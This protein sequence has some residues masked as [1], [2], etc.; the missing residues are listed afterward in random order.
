MINH[1]VSS[2]Q[3]QPPCSQTVWNVL[4]NWAVIKTKVQGLPVSFFAREENNLWFQEQDSITS[5]L[6]ALLKRQFY[7]SGNLVICCNAAV[8]ALCPQATYHGTDCSLVTFSRSSPT[9]SHP[10]QHSCRQVETPKLVCLTKVRN[11]L[12]EGSQHLGLLA[13][14][15]T[16]HSLGSPRSPNRIP[17]L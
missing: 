12:H 8:L 6:V 14:W 13:P 1:G 4:L 10:P 3:K 16:S 11:A 2:S 5:I 9:H 17:I 7:L 15:E